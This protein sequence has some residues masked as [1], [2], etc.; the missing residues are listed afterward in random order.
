MASA[1]VDRGLVVDRGVA[2][3]LLDLTGHGQESLLDVGGVLC[4]SLQEWNAERI[5]KLL[6]SL[7]THALDFVFCG[8]PNLGNSVL[9]DL[10][11]SH[12]ALVAD[13]KLVDTLGCVAVNLLEPLLDVV[14]AV[15]VG[16][17]VDDANAVGAAVVGRRDGAETLLSGRVPL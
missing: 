5:S 10:L 12:I 17:I 11:V 2:H 14:E 15:H 7:S 4:R 3:T 6:V 9:D 16:D 8:K 13:K 1:N